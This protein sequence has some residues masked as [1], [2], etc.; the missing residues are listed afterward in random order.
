MVLLGARHR[1][2]VGRNGA[3]LKVGDGVPGAFM[4]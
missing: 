1:Q 4:L 2:I 3:N